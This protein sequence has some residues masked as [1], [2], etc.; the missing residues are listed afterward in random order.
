LPSIGAQ[1]RFPL[2]QRSLLNLVSREPAVFESRVNRGHG[3]S[4]FD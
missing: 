1:R 3:I 4:R 2:I